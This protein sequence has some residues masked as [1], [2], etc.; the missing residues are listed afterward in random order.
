[1]Q[2]KHYSTTAG[3]EPVRDFISELP[4]ES[5]IEVLTLLRRMEGGE[6]LPMPLSR[7]MASMA[8]GLYELRVRDSQ[9]QIRIFYYTK[10][11]D[12]IYLVHALRKKSQTMPDKDRILI[13]KRLQ[14]L[15]RLR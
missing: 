8:S 14:D 9:G 10:V 12:A 7:S 6:I 11:K 5:R 3:R 1:M 15:N 2:I 4:E 13:L